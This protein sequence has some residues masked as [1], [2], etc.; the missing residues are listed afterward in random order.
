MTTTDSAVA[1]LNLQD[2]TFRTDGPEVAAARAAG[3]YARTPFGVGV[4]RHD[5][6]SDLLSDRRLRQGT[7]RV[8]ANQ[9]L[10]EGPIVDWM[11]SI[12][13]STEGA[14]H[15]RLRRLVSRA[16][17]PRS[18][19]ELRPRMREVADELIDGFAGAGNVEFMAAFADPYPARIICE[20]LGVPATLHE[21]FRGWANDLGLAFGYTAAANRDRIEAAIAGLDAA[22]DE[23]LAARRAEPGPDL[24]SALLAAEAD[25][26]RLTNGELRLLVTGLLFAGQDTTHHQLGQALS[27]FLRHPD[28]WAL[29]ADRPELVDRAVTEVLRLAPTT[30]VVGRLATEDIEVDGVA[31]PAGTHVTM[32]LVAGNTDPAVFGPDATRFD[33]TAERPPPLTFGAGIHYCLGANL[34]RAELAEA[35]PILAR[36]LGPI[37][38]AGDAA[39]R[40]S[41]GI[42]GPVTL[43][44]RFGP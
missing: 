14:D 19:S 29:L 32:F 33:I 38:A 15:T 26:D 6:L 28:Q 44:I 27:M 8:L 35:L 10:T 31:I 22:T 1:F 23:L 41:V 9:G 34:A 37:T 43:P 2:P 18:V 24:L 11:N 21:Q 17:T 25:G 5:Q 16:F 13:L 39:W 7:H 12:I 40:P 30:P 3:W 42:T 4:L 36:R 20:L